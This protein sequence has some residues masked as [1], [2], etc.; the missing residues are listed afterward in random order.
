MTAV[1]AVQRCLAAE[2][3]CLYG[4]G[5][6]GGVL[7]GVAAGSNDQARADSSYAEHRALRDGL[8]AVVSRLNAEPVPAEAAY[9]VPFLVGSLADCRRLA[10]AL[11]HKACGVYAFALTETV[12]DLRTLIA[13]ALTDC[14]L[15]EYAWGSQPQ[16]FPG[17]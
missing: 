3:A 4:Y 6:L 10:R 13:D 9:D 14:A 12:D 1:D 11:E 5:V 16:A 2:H 8:T 15:R 17:I 7:A